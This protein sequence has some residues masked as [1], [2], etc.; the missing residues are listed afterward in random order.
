MSQFVTGS[1]KIQFNCDWFISLSNYKL[2]YH[3]IGSQL[4]EIAS[5]FKPITFEESAIF[6]IKNR[7]KIAKLMLQSLALSLRAKNQ[8]ISLAI[9]LQLKCDIN[10][11]STCLTP[12][13]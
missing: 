9:Y 6:M 1:F 10:F 4:V 2:S 7:K 3:M 13:F 5:S 12:S 11:L 8:N